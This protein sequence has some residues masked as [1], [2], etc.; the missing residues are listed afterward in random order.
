M[1]FRSVY[2]G[3]IVARVLSRLYGEDFGIKWV[4]DILLRNKKI[5]GI[6]AEST[7]NAVVM[8]I[9]INL[10]TPMEFFGEELPNAGSVGG[11]LGID[12]KL[13]SIAAELSSEF[14]RYSEGEKEYLD[15]L[16]AYYK[17]S[18]VTLGREVVVISS[19]ETYG[20]KAVDILEDGSLLVAT[21]NG[22]RT[23]VFGDV[24][25]RGINGYI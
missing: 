25:V 14:I 2:G 19:S 4:N 23:V 6:L 21:E 16:F 5:C 22:T 12:C 11:I 13:H 3:A 8:G 10:N 17:K 20:G 9:G 1:L 24:S 7:G 15:E 18:L